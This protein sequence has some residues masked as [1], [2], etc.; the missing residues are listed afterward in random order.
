MRATALCRSLLMGIFY[1]FI[2]ALVLIDIFSLNL[3]NV[4]IKRKRV[5]TDADPSSNNKS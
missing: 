2:F 3:Y 1:E 4:I 5:D